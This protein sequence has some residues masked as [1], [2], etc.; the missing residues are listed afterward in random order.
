MKHCIVGEDYER[1][2]EKKKCQL[3]NLCRKEN[4]KREK[5]SDVNY[6]YKPKK[7]KN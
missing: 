5:P 4:E 6:L 3:K 2:C 1:E 7:D